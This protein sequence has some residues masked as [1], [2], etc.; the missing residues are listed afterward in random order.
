M[1]SATDI[2]RPSRRTSRRARSSVIGVLLV[3]AA[4]TAG[5]PL[6]GRA[7]NDH[8]RLPDGTLLELGPDDDIAVL[9]VTGAGWA[10]SKAES[11]PDSMYVLTRDGVDLVAGYVALT[12][13]REVEELWEGLRKVQSVG[14]ENARLGA[15]RPVTSAGGAAGETGTLTRGGRTGTAS[16]WLAPDKSYAVEITVL[17]GPDAEPRVSADAAATVRSIAF[18]REA[19]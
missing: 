14:D 5:W 4:L 18:P 15:P 2:R 11:D 9:R 16:V 8:E 1:D 17:A 12:A 3:M 13:P 10:L 6:I 7:L 19:P